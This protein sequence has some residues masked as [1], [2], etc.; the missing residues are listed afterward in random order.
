MSHM[1][2]EF[3]FL[4]NICVYLFLQDK[5]SIESKLES[6]RPQSCDP[7]CHALETPSG[8]ECRS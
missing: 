7:L 5:M 8:I 6:R 2:H 4:S 3:Y 1:S